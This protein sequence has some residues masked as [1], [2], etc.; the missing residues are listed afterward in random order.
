MDYLPVI[1]NIKGKKCLIVGGGKVAARKIKYLLGRVE[2]TVISK[3]FCREIKDMN[4]IKLV[5]KAYDSSD[6]DGFDIVIA[7]TNDERTNK[8]IFLDAQNKNVLVNNATS[9]EYCDFLMPAFFNYKDFIVAVSSFGNSP[10][11][12]KNLKEKIK[13][14]LEG[15]DV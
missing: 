2:I 8:Q 12:A 1:L 4:G 9:K 11:R 5:R 14:Y 6:L 13:K 7:A 15:L 10:K 3:D